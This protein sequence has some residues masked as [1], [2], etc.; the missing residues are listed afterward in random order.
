MRAKQVIEWP[1]Y[2]GMKVFKSLTMTTLAKAF[3]EYQWV[4]PA[5]VI[6]K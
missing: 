4:S 2:F 3:V 1:S 5:K 6:A